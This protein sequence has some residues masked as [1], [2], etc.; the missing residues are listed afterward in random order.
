MLWGIPHCECEVHWVNL[1][2]FRSCLKTR[3]NVF[4][5]ARE[6][7]EFASIP[8]DFCFLFSQ[9]R[10]ESYL[11]YRLVVLFS[12]FAHF[13]SKGLVDEETWF[14]YSYFKQLSLHGR[15]A[16]FRRTSS[17]FWRVEFED[18]I[19]SAERRWDLRMSG[20]CF[21]NFSKNPSRGAF[22]RVENLLRRFSYSRFISLP[23]PS[24]SIPSPKSTLP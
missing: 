8:Q 11:T 9:L 18:R 21:V 3:G 19:R 14:A 15:S 2:G 22:L 10:L 24:R 6:T 16:V 17:G 4:L 5:R 12:R 7:S 20:L 13:Y 1:G 23:P